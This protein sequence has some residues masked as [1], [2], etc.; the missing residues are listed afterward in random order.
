MSGLWPYLAAL[1]PVAGMAWLFWLVMKSLVEADRSE[2]RAHS[3]WERDLR[4]REELPPHQDPQS[5]ERDVQ[6]PPEVP[7]KT[8]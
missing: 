3:Q 2:R 7:R 4:P 1:I 8:G 6:K 5:R